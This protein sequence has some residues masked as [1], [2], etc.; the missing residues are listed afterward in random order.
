VSAFN[1]YIVCCMLCDDIRI[2]RL[3]CVLHALKRYHVNKDDSLGVPAFI[4]CIVFYTLRG[5]V[6]MWDFPYS[7]FALCFERFKPI[8]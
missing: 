2:Q 1:V 4:V 5:D 6:R 7:T 3:Y 8:P